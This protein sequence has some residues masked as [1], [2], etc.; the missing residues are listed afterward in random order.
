M[1]EHKFRVIFE[2]GSCVFIG[3]V[4]SSELEAKCLVEY[5]LEEDGCTN[6][7]GVEYVGTR[8]PSKNWR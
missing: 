7:V 3:K 5:Q 6:Y 8:V 2:N 1:L 4:A